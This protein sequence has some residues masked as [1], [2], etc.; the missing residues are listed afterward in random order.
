MG[1]R[2]WTAW[3]AVMLGL[4][5]V[6]APA[7]S[8]HQSHSELTQR[9]IDGYVVP[10]LAAFQAASGTL[11]TGMTSYCAAPS[12]AQ[13]NKVTGQFRD[14]LVA[15]ARVEVIRTGPATRD[16]RA[17]KIA[18]W[19]DPRGAVER[20]L[21]QALAQRQ[22]ELTA[23][24]TLRA[25]SAALQGFPALELLLAD[26][27]PGIGGP[28]E[29]S[30]YRCRVASAIATNIADLS[31]EL[32][33][34]WVHP[35]G[36]RDHMLRPGSDNAD[37]PSATASA[38]DI[39]KSLTTSLQAIIEAQIQPLILNDTDKKPKASAKAYRHLG[40]SREY[41]LAGINGCRALYGA[42]H[43]GGYLDANDPA[44][45]KLAGLIETAFSQTERQVSAKGW[46]GAGSDDNEGRSRQAR[47]A[48]SML[49]AARRII[50]TNVAGTAEISLGFNELD[51]D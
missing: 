39:F 17:Q 32:N 25:Q 49:A 27:A 21:R 10:S 29:E 44:Q 9:A 14:A 12:D 31:R 48:S 19:P 50:A 3:T 5:A 36:W 34:G 7:R 46:D 6:A 24:E 18:F 22:P 47:P 38:T 20:Q 2:T 11:A 8:E 13:R 33:D 15:W 26:H 43:L 1:F 51:G 30:R 35:G 40:M 4:F 42:A 45:A 16:G 23:P 41:L 28:D 37:F